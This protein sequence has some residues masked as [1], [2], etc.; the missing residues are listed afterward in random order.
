MKWGGYVAYGDRIMPYAYALQRYSMVEIPVR[1][2][3]G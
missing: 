3:V 1:Q 2:S